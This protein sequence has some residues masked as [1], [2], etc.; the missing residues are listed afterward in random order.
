MPLYPKA[1]CDKLGVNMNLLKQ[2]STNIY[3]FD[4]KKNHQKY[5]VSRGPYKD[6][7][8]TLMHKDS[9]DPSNLIEIRR[10]TKDGHPCKGQYGLFAKE[11]IPEGTIFYPYGGLWS[12]WGVSEVVTNGVEGSYHFTEY[13]WDHDMTDPEKYVCDGLLARNLLAYANH[14]LQS[15]KE[16]FEVIANVKIA[17]LPVILYRMKV[18]CKK[19]EELFVNYGYSYFEQQMVGKQRYDNQCVLY[20]ENMKKQEKA[21]K[22]KEEVEG[23][24]NSLKTTF[25]ITGNDSSI[26]SIHTM[27]QKQIVEVEEKR[28]ALFKK[29][30]LLQNQN[31]R[32]IKTNNKL[33]SMNKKLLKTKEDL[34]K[35]VKTLKET[36]EEVE[37]EKSKTENALSHLKTHFSNI[38]FELRKKKRQENKTFREK[39]GAG[40][41]VGMQMFKCVYGQVWMGSPCSV[42]IGKLQSHWN[43]PCKHRK[44]I[45]VSYGLTE[46]EDETRYNV[47]KTPKEGRTCNY[48]YPILRCKHNRLHRWPRANGVTVEAH[49]AVCPD[50]PEFDKDAASHHD[51]LLKKCTERS[52]LLGN[53]IDVTTKDNDGNR[54]ITKREKLIVCILFVNG[55][56]YYLQT[57][58]TDVNAMAHTH[59]IAKEKVKIADTDIAIMNK[60]IKQLNMDENYFSA[61]DKEI[62]LLGHEKKYIENGEDVQ[63]KS[64]VSY[65]CIYIYVYSQINQQYNL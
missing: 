46:F 50:N 29:T 2:V 53:N 64:R 52:A 8:K 18:E 27:M 20:K 30:I 34:S 47:E 39:T 9:A 57:K 12:E 42:Q 1:I 48:V 58:D 41:L 49:H 5:K 13:S 35:T 54:I 43:K 7:I 25:N 17:N 23:L 26:Q 24:I 32:V 11:D 62:L 44:S 61:L 37:K 3:T 15:S 56:N 28:E 19:G 63:L 33:N 22:Q 31:G 55:A 40:T 38:N 10:I 51:A 65:I 14:P 36:N 16:H 60:L 45:L 6:R 4:F 21:R 59:H